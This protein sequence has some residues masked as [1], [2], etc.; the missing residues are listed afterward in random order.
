[1]FLPLP[2][3]Y[4]GQSEIGYSQVIAAQGV[5]N[6]HFLTLLCI[7]QVGDSLAI[8]ELMQQQRAR[9]RSSKPA[10]RLAATLLMPG[11]LRERLRELDDF[12]LWKVPAPPRC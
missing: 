4:R 5:A 6:N 9:V 3:V 2:E 11:L 1:M 7:L 12:Q 8:P 10:E